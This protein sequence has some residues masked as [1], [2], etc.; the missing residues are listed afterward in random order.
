[1]KQEEY[2]ISHTLEGC[3][4]R[5][6]ITASKKIHDSSYKKAL[7]EVNSE[8]EVKGFRK[9]KVP[10][11]LLQQYYP[12]KIASKAR[13]H[14]ASHC[15]EACLATGLYRPYKKEYRIE[16]LSLDKEHPV[17]SVSFEV[18]PQVPSID[19]SLFQPEPFDV[20]QYSK[21]QKELFLKQLQEKHAH[22]TPTEQSV[23]EVGSWVCYSLEVS[24]GDRLLPMR[25]LAH[26]CIPQ[27]RH[28]W[29]EET[30]LQMQANETKKV[31]DAQLAFPATVTLHSIDSI[32]LPLI[33]DALAQKEGIESKE[34]LE[35]L[36]QQRADK[37]AHEE[38]LSLIHI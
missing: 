1:M 37:K 6:T 7:K 23:P 9:N 4:V 31:E 14:I 15:V 13:S 21:E 20:Q 29:L 26:I 32:E 17:C 10:E 19:F 11:A 33:D 35:E 38:H 28:S 25:S 27:E 34:K 2:Q 12:E 24:I 36:L 18:Y 8:V 22:F 5:F 3:R 16:E 30:L